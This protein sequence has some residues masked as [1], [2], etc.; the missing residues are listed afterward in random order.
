MMVFKYVVVQRKSEGDPAYIPLLQAHSA[1]KAG[2]TT[3]QLPPSTGDAWA[4]EQEEV[5]M[6][7][8]LGPADDQAESAA[9]DATVDED[10][11]GEEG[12]GEEGEEE[13]KEDDGGAE[14][15]IVSHGKV[16]GSAEDEE[17][18][19]DYRVIIESML[20]AGQQWIM[21]S[22]CWG[23]RDTKTGQYDM[24]QTVIKVF[25][26][27]VKEHGLP[28]WLDIF[29]GMGGD[30][31]ESMGRGVRGAAVVVPFLS[32]A[33]DTSANG[34][35]ELKFACNLDK[36]LVPVMAEAGFN[37]NDSTWLG[38]CVPGELY[39]P[40]QDQA[41]LA[42]ETQVDDLA[43][44]IKKQLQGMGLGH[45]AWPGATSVPNAAP[46]P[47]GVQRQQSTKNLGRRISR[48]GATADT[49]VGAQQETN[50]VITLLFQN[51]LSKYAAVFKEEGY[52]NLDDLKQLAK[53]EDE[54]WRMLLMRSKMKPPHQ[55]KLRRALGLSAGE[56]APL[57]SS[58]ASTPAAA[59]S[60]DA[61][62]VEQGEVP[63]PVAPMSPTASAT[64]AAVVANQSALSQSIAV[65][66]F[67]IDVAPSK[68]QKRK[69]KNKVIELVNK[70]LRLCVCKN[71]DVDLVL[72]PTDLHLAFS[73]DE[74]GEMQKINIFKLD[75]DV[76]IALRVVTRNTI[77][78]MGGMRSKMAMTVSGKVLVCKA[79]NNEGRAKLRAISNA[80]E[81][82]QNIRIEQ[83]VK[84]FL[85]PPLPD[86]DFIVVLN[87]DEYEAH[88]GQYK[89]V[90]PFNAQDQSHT[91][92]LMSFQFHGCGNRFS[93]K[94]VYRRHPDERLRT[95]I[96]LDQYGQAVFETKRA[97]F[98][99][100]ATKC[101]AKSIE[102]NN[103]ESELASS[104]VKAEVAFEGVSVGGGGAKGEQKQRNQ[105][106]QQN[107]PKPSNAAVKRFDLL[108]PAHF[109]AE[110]T[111]FYQWEPSWQTMVQGR[112]DSK[113][114]TYDCQ[115]TYTADESKSA[116]VKA[117]LAGIVGLDFGGSKEESMSIDE[118][119]TVVFWE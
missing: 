1:R 17:E 37:H 108:T 59:A 35:R 106:M 79:H 38:V 85:L 103:D 42:F 46:A 36:P 49:A 67:G 81:E 8:L 23:K 88:K 91:E 44:A 43:E 87:R 75:A 48:A 5:G 31:Y 73:P 93:K 116:N 27:L 16:A 22:Y 24:Q 2:K 71:C 10:E 33:Y 114:R 26:R 113:M 50:P 12:D 115:F 15:T 30:V 29:G 84:K 19:E 39:H 86:D 13:G 55:R 52:D 25:R 60:D 28:V 4:I 94:L 110:T 11:E 7:K 57:P 107:F 32:S 45:L 58:P 41:Q 62:A 76:L 78:S 47:A 64:A 14:T 98:L 6:E 101:H 72:E 74:A 20:K 51:A 90:R 65:S 69:K 77:S 80:G 102:V 34:K 89:G 99:Q 109:C 68:E 3:M 82:A 118:T 95:F 18:F 100:I 96:P 92:I 63:A 40:I 53:D 117:G 119:C 66:E 61:E 97:E 21:L 104:T 54:E 105:S 56:G 112:L 111:Y 83:L 9:A 70:E